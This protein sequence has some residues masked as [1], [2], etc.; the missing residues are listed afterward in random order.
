MAALDVAGGHVLGSDVARNDA[1]H[2]IAFL[3]EIDAAVPGRL[4]IHM[5]LDN[6][7]ATPPRP[8]RRGWPT[9]PVSTP[10]TPL[11]THPG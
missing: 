3:A 7:P 4:D 10:T 8:Q 2:F 5:L 11:R 1:A 9:T 6:G